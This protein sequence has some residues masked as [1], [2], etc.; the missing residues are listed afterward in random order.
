M[1]VGHSWTTDEAAPAPT[2]GEAPDRA[3]LSHEVITSLVAGF[4]S[5]LPGAVLVVLEQPNWVVVASVA[6]G[7]VAVGVGTWTYVVGRR[8]ARGVR[9]PIGPAFATGRP[10][11]DPAPTTV[12][13]FDRWRQE[14]SHTLFQVLWQRNRP[15]EPI[16]PLRLAAAVAQQAPALISG[17]TTEQIVRAIEEIRLLKWLPALHRNAA[18]FYLDNDDFALNQ[19]LARDLKTE[20]AK[21]AATYVRDGMSIALDGGT[22]TLEVARVI[23]SSFVAKTIERLWITSASLQISSEF[24]EVPECREA[25]RAGAL[26]V[27]CMEGPLHG[28]TTDPPAD[29]RMPWPLDLAIIGSNGITCDGFHLPTE[30]GLQVKKAFIAAAPRTLVVADSGKVGRQL[31]QLFGTWHDSILLITDRPKDRAAKRLLDTMPK[32]RVRYSADILAQPDR[33]TGR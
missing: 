24:S 21:A 11:A 16:H 20:I 26:A 6:V 18:G 29:A 14:L 12:G 27:W 28:W 31:P 4:S 9:R 17:R 15:S 7:V 1:S 33:A 13:E 19:T 23:A 5:A 30:Q 32:D 8:A 10:T 25:I 2:D 22:T 3:R